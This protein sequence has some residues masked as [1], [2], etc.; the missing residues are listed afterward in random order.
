VGKA[1]QASSKAFT[2]LPPGTSEAPVLLIWGKPTT[3]EEADG[4]MRYGTSLMV[5]QRPL[6]T[7]SAAALGLSALLA[8]CGSPTVSPSAPMATPTVLPS[9]SL[10]AT[11]FATSSPTE[12]PLL[13]PS[14]LPDGL[15]YSDLDGVPVTPDLAHR[16]PLAIMIDDSPPARPQSG[17]SSASIVYQAPV[18]AGQ[19][20]YMMIFQ[21]GTASDIGPVRSARP[22]EVYWASEYN[23]MLGHF[24]GDDK[25]LTVVIPSLSGVIYNMDD[26]NGGSCPYHRIAQRVMPHNAYTNSAALIGCLGKKHYPSI[27]QGAPTRP[28]RDDMLPSQR[29]T[30]ASISI[31]YRTGVVGYVYQ[32]D[33]DS[34]LRYVGGKPQVDPANNR[35]V[36][37][38]NVIVMFQALSTD[39]YNRPVV[40]SVGSGTAL[41]FQ[42]GLAITATW[43]KPSNTAL[44]RFYDAAGAEIPLVRGEIF[45]A[46][47]PLGTKV[48]YK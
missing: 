18:D 29:P 33:S 35:Q 16:L 30:S 39:Q 15:S 46:S 38:R 32:P 45:I 26:L 31:P 41:V 37:A 21:E 6:V 24:G 7:L 12:T 28:F 9:A 48:T 20:R 44:T 25:S 11:P 42:E 14:L 2:S 3:N 17:F 10:T 40:A 19:D 47:V 43:N 23:A 27:Y 36:K 34:Y 1:A 8:A 13:S 4:M 22:Y 5:R